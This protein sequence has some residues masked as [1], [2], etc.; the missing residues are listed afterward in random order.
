L[1]P[2]DDP[3]PLVPPELE[4]ELEPELEPLDPPLS[5]FA[6]VFV[7]LLASVFVSLFVSAFASGFELPDDSDDSD[8]LDLGF[9][10]EYASAYQP[11][12]FKMKLPPLIWRF[13]VAFAHAGQ[14]STGGSVIFW[15]S[16]QAFPQLEH[17]YSYVGMAV[18]LRLI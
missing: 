6:S 10:D 14:T 17:T 7:S 13:A 3:E 5:F 11:P 18:W 16:S 9:A 1:E 4:L 12:P 8:D 15:S 2:L